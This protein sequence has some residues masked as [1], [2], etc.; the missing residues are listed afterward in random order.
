MAQ[1]DRV[2]GQAVTGQA[3]SQE[4]CW[5]FVEEGDAEQDHI[6]MLAA[7]QRKRAVRMREE[8]AEIRD[9]N[10]RLLQADRPWR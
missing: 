2:T 10:R 4:S 8:A 3:S 6:R 1:E 5:R 7:G 9:R